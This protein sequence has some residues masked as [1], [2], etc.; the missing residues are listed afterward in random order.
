[1]RFHSK[2][3]RGFQ[4][5]WNIMN[6]LFLIKKKRMESCLMKLTE[7]NKQS[8]LNRINRLSDIIPRVSSNDLNASRSM[9]ERR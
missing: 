3:F 5:F 9:R 6:Y 8:R 7:Y 2:E 4:R 1:M